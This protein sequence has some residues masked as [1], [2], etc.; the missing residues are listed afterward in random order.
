M[1]MN[2]KGFRMRRDHE[3]KQELGHNTGSSR[4]TNRPEQPL[5]DQQKSSPST[6]GN[7]LVSRLRN[8]IRKVLY[9]TP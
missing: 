2:S 9:K 3:A 6:H 5:E 7:S 8:F 4:T 1:V